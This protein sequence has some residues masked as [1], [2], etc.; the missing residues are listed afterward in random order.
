MPVGEMLL[1]LFAVFGVYALFVRVLLG[2]IPRHARQTVLV[3]SGEETQAQALALFRGMRET[4]SAVVLLSVQTDEGTILALKEAG[5][6]L[7]CPAE[8]KL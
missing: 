3:L 6:V 7:Y 5:A 8:R 4:H 2:L 1:A